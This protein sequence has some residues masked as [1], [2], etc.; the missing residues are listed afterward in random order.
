MEKTN[1]KS[2][3]WVLLSLNMNDYT[4]ICVRERMR[5][6]PPFGGYRYLGGGHPDKVI[7]RYGDRLVADS[8]ILE[9]ALILYVVPLDQQLSDHWG[10]YCNI[11]RTDGG[12]RVCSCTGTC[13]ICSAADGVTCPLERE[14]YAELEVASGSAAGVRDMPEQPGREKKLATRCQFSDESIPPKEV[15]GPFL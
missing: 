12:V 15:C 11:G 10:D 14:D 13:S 7:Q 3:K 4:H 1:Y 5:L 6:Y 2:V 8:C 9:D